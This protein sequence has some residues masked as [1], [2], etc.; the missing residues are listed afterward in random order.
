VSNSYLGSFLQ[1]CSTIFNMRMFSFHIYP[2]SLDYTIFH[3]NFE[4]HLMTKNILCL[5]TPLRHIELGSLSLA[6]FH[7]RENVPF[8]RRIIVSLVLIFSL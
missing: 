4:Q 2:Q 7:A 5:W 3:D 6:I 8:I 1:I